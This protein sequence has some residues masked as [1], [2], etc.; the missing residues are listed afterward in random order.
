MNAVGRRWAVLVRGWHTVGRHHLTTTTAR[1]VSGFH[2]W[3]TACTCT[4]V[5]QG[6]AHTR[7]AAIAEAAAHVRPRDR[8]QVR[9]VHGSGAARALW[10]VPAL[11][12]P[13][14]HLA[15]P[16]ELRGHG[17]IVACDGSRR[18]RDGHT[19]WGVITDAGWWL[20]GVEHPR[21]EINGLELLAI[22]HAVRLY[23]KGSTFVVLSDSEAARAV[24]RAIL[25]GRV[26]GLS[27]LPRWATQ[28][29][30][31]MLRGA[32]QRGVKVT[33]RAVRSKTHPLHDIADRLARG[34]AVDQALLAGGGHR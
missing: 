33:I 21:R 2:L 3:H 11:R 26:T 12:V 9:E 25:G 29:A 7:V 5:W 28:S 13:A 14:R 24:A 17:R 15:L 18:V 34:F 31:V 23:P 4:V 20:A 32:Y 10:P 16:D 19:G 22:A 1:S 6:A 8:H 30:F 27:A